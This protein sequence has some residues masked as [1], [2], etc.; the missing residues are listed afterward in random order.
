[1]IEEKDEVEALELM[2]L[3]D[4]AVE[5][6]QQFPHGIYPDCYFWSGTKPGCG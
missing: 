2:D 6:K 5:T 4:A 3:G 1:M